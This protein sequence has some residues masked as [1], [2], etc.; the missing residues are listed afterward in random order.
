MEEPADGRCNLV[1]Y[2]PS[3]GDGVSELYHTTNPPDVA[4]DGSNAH[5]LLAEIHENTRILLDEHQGDFNEGE[6]VQ[7]NFISVQC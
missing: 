4:S 3:A 7:S 1:Y 5:T 2:C 6:S